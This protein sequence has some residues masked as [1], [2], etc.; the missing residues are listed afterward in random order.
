MSRYHFTDVS[1]RFG[2]PMGRGACHASPD[3]AGLVRIERVRMV[4]GD[5]DRGGAYWG[6]GGL[7]LFVVWSVDVD[8][9]NA[10]IEYFERAPNRESMKAAVRKRYPNVRFYR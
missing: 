4:D 3:Y 1:S 5:Y 6:G 9:D 8:D 7:P 2:A 10:A